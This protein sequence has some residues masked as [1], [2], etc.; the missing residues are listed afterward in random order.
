MARRPPQPPPRP[1][2]TLALT[3]T[4]HKLLA[5]LDADS[6]LG[7]E[8]AQQWQRRQGALKV[9]AA[10]IV[11]RAIAVYIGHLARADGL[12]EV[13]ATERACKASMRTEE[14]HRLALLRLHAADLSAP[15]P[16]FEVVRDGAR[17][18]AERKAMHERLNQL[19]ET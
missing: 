15:L 4:H 16:P 18:V 7:I 13:R 11:R 19:L 17:V 9:P 1:R 14:D 3:G 2:T 8:H 6:L 10:G 12:A 5:A